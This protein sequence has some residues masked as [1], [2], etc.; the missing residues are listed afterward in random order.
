MEKLKLDSEF[1]DKLF[2][3]LKQ[4][5]HYVFAHPEVLHELPA[6]AALVLLDP[7]DEEFN[8]QNVE[9]AKSNRYPEEVPLVYVRMTKQVKVVQQV[10]W[11][12]TIMPAPLA[13]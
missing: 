7:E 11:T 3:L 4:F 1:H 13:A 2:D 6:K 9:L 12:P 10:E 8:R 5:N